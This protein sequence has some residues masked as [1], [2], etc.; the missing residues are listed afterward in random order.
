MT[1]SLQVAFQGATL[2]VV[3]HNNQPYVPMKPV[4]EGMGLAWQSQ[5]TKLKSNPRWSITEIVTVAEDGKQREMS[6]LPLRKLPGWMASIH[7]NKVKPEIRQKVIA[8]QEQCD[9]ILW[10]AWNGR[11][12]PAA[13]QIDTPPASLRNRGWLVTIDHNGREIATPV[14]RDAFWITTA[15]MPSMLLNPAF[16]IEN[17]ELIAISIACSKRL[18]RRFAAVAAKRN[19][20]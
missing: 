10:D 12:A 15:E 9:D 14:P 18:Q 4:I 17:E 20:V 6:C 7:P 3:E 11:T 13:Q 8:F 5:S 2:L 19:K 16:L 1:T